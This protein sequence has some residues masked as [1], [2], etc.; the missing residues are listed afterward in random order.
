MPPAQFHKFKVNEWFRDKAQF[1]TKI[2]MFVI[3]L[4][5]RKKKKIIK[6]EEYRAFYEIMR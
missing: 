6:H 5:I 4:K 2:I 3:Q 1:K